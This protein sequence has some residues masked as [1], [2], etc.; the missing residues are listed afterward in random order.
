MRC[1][2]LCVT[3]CT[4]APAAAGAQAPPIQYDPDS[5]AGAEY[6]VPLAQARERDGGAGGASGAS[7]RQ[8]GSGLFGTGIRRVPST[9]GASSSD[10]AASQARSARSPESASA[11]PVGA[12]QSAGAATGGISGLT[13]ALGTGLAVLVVGLGGAGVLGRRSRAVPG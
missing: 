7:P 6:A 8:D 13:V 9:A 12:S 5:T 10:P 11:G 2:A 3:V 4:A 1:V